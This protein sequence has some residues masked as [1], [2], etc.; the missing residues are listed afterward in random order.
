MMNTRSFLLSALIAG[1][2]MAL[3]GNLPL[4][5]VLNCILCIYAWLGGALA[6][7]LYGRFQQGQFSLSLGQAAGLGAT[8]G[9][10]GALI[11]LLAF[12]IFGQLSTPILDKVFSF[13]LGD[14]ALQLP[15]P[16]SQVGGP[17]G[18]LGAALTFFVVDAVLYTL[19]STLAAVLAA[20]LMKKPA[21]AG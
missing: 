11:G 1:A 7:Y 4:V 5:N 8:S 16:G 13:A 15:A 3:L 10:F 18:L 12:L 14:G 6:I 2:V 17:F 20:S 21:A 9:I 19:F